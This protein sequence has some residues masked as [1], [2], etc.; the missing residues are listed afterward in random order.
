MNR[1]SQWISS[2]HDSYENHFY[3]IIIFVSREILWKN[4]FEFIC[5]MRDRCYS[6]S[7]RDSSEMNGTFYLIT[8]KTNLETQIKLYNYKFLFVLLQII[9]Q[10]IM[11]NTWNIHIFLKCKY[12]LFWGVIYKILGVVFNGNVSIKEESDDRLLDSIRRNF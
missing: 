2:G 11:W 3:F 6:R 10:D 9:Y 8:R 1:F 5:W 7:G 12:F 4:I